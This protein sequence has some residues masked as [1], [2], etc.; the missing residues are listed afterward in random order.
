[1]NNNNE[2]AMKIFDLQNNS[3]AELL[4][5]V[6][7]EHQGVV[8]SARKIVDDSE[9]MNI[10]VQNTASYTKYLYFLKKR[11]PWMQLKDRELISNEPD[12]ILD[13]NRIDTS[14]YN[15][16]SFLPKNFYIQFSKPANVYFTV[17]SFI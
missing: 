12:Q 16:L 14:K 6:K 8:N 5:E 4:Q 13:D 10:N 1:M 9:P 2:S 17:N 11:T 3:K 15:S 7:L